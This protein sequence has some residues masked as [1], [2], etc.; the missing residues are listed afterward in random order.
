MSIRNLALV[1][2]LLLA[3]T[4]AQAEE[5]YKCTDAKGAVSIQSDPCPKGST[6]VWKRDAAPDPAPS[7]DELAARA[8]IAQAEAERAAEAARLAEQRRL[9][10]RE[11]RLEELLAREAAPAGPPPRRS[12]CTIAHDFSDTAK[13]VPRLDLNQAQRELIQRW[14]EDQCRDPEAPVADST[15]L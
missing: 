13:T 8:A 12:S 10:E 15:D 4:P 11:R 5:L 3:T 1:G 6:E 14:V 7:A 2:A 9:A